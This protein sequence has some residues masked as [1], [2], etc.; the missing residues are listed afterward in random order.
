MRGLSLDQ[1]HTFV[2]VVERGSFSAAADRLDLTQPAVSLQV[3]QLEKRLGVRLI[4]RVGRRAQPTPAGAELLAHARRIAQ[5]VGAAEESLAPYASGTLGRV[6]IGTGATACIHFLPAVLRDLRRRFPKL[7]IIIGTGNATDV[8]RQ[9]EENKL[10]LGL[11]T[12]PAPGRMFD[13]TPLLEDEFVVLSSPEGPTLP[14]SVT[15]QHLTRHPIVLYEPGAQTRRIVD[16]WFAA[17]GLSIRPT[18]EL[19]SVEAMKELVRA[20]LGVGIVPRM[21]VDRHRTPKLQIQSLTPRLTRTIGLVIRRDKPLHRGLR[22]TIAALRRAAPRFSR[23]RRK[24]P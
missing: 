19:G 18:M 15:A 11:V 17:A 4:E 6:R 1:L 10:D 21:A 12:L 23:T 9:L 3:R 16:D 22:E 14:R 8:L 7:E 20:G 2:E 5:A 13:V 24:P